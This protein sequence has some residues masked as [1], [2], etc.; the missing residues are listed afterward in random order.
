MYE[1]EF[2]LIILLIG[3]LVIIYIMFS[4]KS[5]RKY[6]VYKTK[7]Y[8]I[9]NPIDI[10]SDHSLVSNKKVNIQLTT[11]KNV[12]NLKKDILVTSNKTKQ[13]SLSLGQ[14]QEKTFIIINSIARNHY[15]IKDIQDF[16][17][18]KNI[19]LNNNGYYDKFYNDNRTRCVK[20]SV[21]NMINPGYLDKEKLEDL[22]IKGVSFFM[23]LPLPIDTLIAFDEMLNDAKAFTK[24]YKGSLHDSDKKKLDNKIIKNFKK[25]ASSYNDEY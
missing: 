9:K 15:N 18:K 5:N 8:D 22:N 3:F 24:K 1:N 17:D 6:K 16:M 12:K 23:Q 25:I 2:R 14:N 21:T 20:Y 11:N 4:G 19:F 13:M 7:N 10:R